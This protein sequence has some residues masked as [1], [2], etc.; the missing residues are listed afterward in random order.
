MKFK[1]M[2]EGVGSR[3]KN[4]HEGSLEDLY[5]LKSA[6]SSD[7]G[8]EAAKDL[9]KVFF[10]KNDT[11][12]INNLYTGYGLTNTAKVGVGIGM[13]GYAYAQIENPTRAMKEQAR[14]EYIQW[15]SENQ[16]IEA[17]LASRSDGAGYTMTT[18]DLMANTQG[19]S[20]LVFALHRNRNGGY[21]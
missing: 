5:Y 14:S 9:S 11:R 18:N 21:L 15:Q 13:A 6:L 7:N 17:P 12:S 20:D 19:Q 4:F 8:K 3:A 2:L 10:R 1:K 16:D